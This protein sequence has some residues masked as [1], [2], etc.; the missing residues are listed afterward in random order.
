MNPFEKL[1]Q[2]ET[3]F[4]NCPVAAMAAADGDDDEE[5]EKKEQQ[6]Q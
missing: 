4:V 3:I 6:N 5:E 1:K 2:L